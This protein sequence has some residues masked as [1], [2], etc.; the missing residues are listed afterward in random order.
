MH[1]INRLSKAQRVVVVVALGLALAAV[2]SYLVS[3]GVG[4]RMGH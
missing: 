2:G 3:L 1:L 4:F